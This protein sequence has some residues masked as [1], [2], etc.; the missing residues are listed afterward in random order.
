MP[1]ARAKQYSLSIFDYID[2]DLDVDLSLFSYI[3]TSKCRDKDDGPFIQIYCIFKSPKSV[4]QVKRLF[5]KSHPRPVLGKVSAAHY[6][7]CVA[8]VKTGE[9]FHEEGRLPY[10]RKVKEIDQMSAWDDAFWFAQRGQF[11][12]IT[13]LIYAKYKD[14]LHAIHE[15]YKA[16]QQREENRLTFEQNRTKYLNKE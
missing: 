12:Q 7:T 13:P 5:P 1:S 6:T 11:E 16:E 9:S 15:D 2:T 8:F 4:A 10:A 3:C 14:N